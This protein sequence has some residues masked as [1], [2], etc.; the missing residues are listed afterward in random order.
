MSPVLSDNLMNPSTLASDA[1]P[2]AAVA[3]DKLAALP[4]ITGVRHWSS[5]MG[6]TVVI[7]M[8]DP[9]PY[10]VHRLMSP[11]RIYFDLHDTAL[12]HDLDGKTMDV[13]DASLSRVRI[14]QPVA[15]V[16]RIVLDTKDGSNF[17]VSMES[18]PYRL[19]VELRGSEKTLAA[20]RAFGN[21]RVV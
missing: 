14:A 19:V 11:E 16:T 10:E 8:E 12:S 13:G 2:L 6:S 15:G 7:D 20:N 18:N 4:K 21:G 1:A 5:S 3:E 17:S 9:V